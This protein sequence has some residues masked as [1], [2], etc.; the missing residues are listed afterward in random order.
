MGS[1]GQQLVIHVPLGTNKVSVTGKNQ[2]D[3]QANWVGEAARSI[4]GF[5][6]AETSNW[7]WKGVAQVSYTDSKGKTSSF[8][9]PDIPT[10]QHKGD[11]F[12]VA[13]PGV[14]VQANE[15]SREYLPEN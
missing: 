3:Q 8:N 13:A 11:T 12:T 6:V 2:N 10:A 4:L 9:T 15:Q 7:W 5:S 14:N 1:N